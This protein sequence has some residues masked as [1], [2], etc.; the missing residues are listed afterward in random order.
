MPSG[1]QRWGCAYRSPYGAEGTQTSPSVFRQR[2]SLCILPTMQDEQARLGSLSCPQLDSLAGPLVRSP[3]TRDTI[4]LTPATSSRQVVRVKGRDRS[5][6]KVGL[7]R[8]RWSCWY[9]STNWVQIENDKTPAVQP[10]ASWVRQQ[11]RAETYISHRQE[12]QRRR[13][14]GFKVFV[15]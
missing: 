10:S 12:A 6:T 9:G 11:R 2:R 4:S 13:C 1:S 14:H 8:V 15:D 3:G 7:D 5:S